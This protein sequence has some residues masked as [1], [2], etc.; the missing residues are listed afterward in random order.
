M[1]IKSRRKKKRNKRKVKNH[2]NN[3]DKIYSIIIKIE[4]SESGSYTELDKIIGENYTNS[5]YMDDLIYSKLGNIYDKYFPLRIKFLKTI[6]YLKI[7]KLKELRNL[8]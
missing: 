3:Y 8:N 6:S 4:Q 5:L 1:K 7:K 2:I